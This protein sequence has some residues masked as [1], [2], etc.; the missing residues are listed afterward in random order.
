VLARR[1]GAGHTRVMRRALALVFLLT[2]CDSGTAESAAGASK[3]ASNKAAKTESKPE[4]KTESKPDA[5]PAAGGPV[6]DHTV[7]MNDGS[8]KSLADYRGKVLLVVNTASQCGLTPQ[9]EGL[10]ELYAK[11]KGRGF[12]VLAFPS[13]DF[14]GQEPGSAEEIAAFVDEKYSA[15]FP[16]FA[17]VPVKGDAKVPLYATLTEQTADGIKGEIKWNFTKFLVD[18]SGHVVARYEPNVDPMDTA[19]TAKL[20][21]LLPG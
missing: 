19:L 17:K 7:Q 6:L 15:D 3:P 18:A 16:L 13:N 11:Y 1:P 9:Y 5:T 14:G 10:Q 20:E 8:D 2:A 12:E 4:S 21:S